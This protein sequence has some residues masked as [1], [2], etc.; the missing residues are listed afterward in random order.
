MNFYMYSDSDKNL[1]MMLPDCVSDD[2]ILKLG[3][4]IEPD[5]DSIPDDF[6]QAIP[7]KPTGILNL[8]N[9]HASYNVEAIYPDTVVPPGIN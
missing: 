5:L 9:K 6:I 7:K 2:E 4:M 1:M 8:Y 3:D